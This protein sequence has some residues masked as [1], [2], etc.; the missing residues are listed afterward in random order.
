MSYR[1]L[2][3]DGRKF[4]YVV[5]KETTKVREGNGKSIFFNNSNIGNP[6]GYV[7]NRFDE[8]QQKMLFSVT[9]TGKV[10]ITPKNVK[11]AILKLPIP[12]FECRI[13]SI[14]T[15]IVCVDPFSFEIYGKKHIVVCCP[16]CVYNSAM[17]I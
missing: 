6:I 14:K 5:G 11:N 8:Q 2:I 15:V 4:K 3:F 13:H 7:D 1:N 10:I 17:D 12:I 9:K 16:E